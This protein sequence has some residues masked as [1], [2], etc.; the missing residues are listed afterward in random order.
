MSRYEAYVICTAPR[1]GS[2]LLCGLLRTTDIAGNPGSHF[3]VPSLE[4]WQEAYGI[5]AGPSHDDTLKSVFNAALTKGTKGGLFGLRMQRPSFPFFIERT[6]RLYPARTDRETIQAA[7]GRT[8]FIHLT[9]KDKLAQAV[10][11]VIAEQTGLWHRNA[12]GSELERLA[13]GQEPRFDRDAIAQ[14]VSEQTQFDKDW[15]NWFAQEALNPPRI[16]YDALSADPQGTLALILDAL[17]LDPSVAQ[18]IASPTAKLSDA[19]SE[20]WIKQYNAAGP[21]SEAV[22]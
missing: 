12:D 16:D 6:R 4:G 1:S 21:A 15:E 10:S 13:P 22:Q 7:F 19:T 20:Q 8:L 11:R 5:Q 14:H 18:A 17:G 9:R 2:T 3:H